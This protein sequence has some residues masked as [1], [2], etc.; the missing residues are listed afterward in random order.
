MKKPLME[1]RTWALVASAV[2]GGLVSSVVTTTWIANAQGTKPTTVMVK[3]TPKPV[4]QEAPAPPVVEVVRL[5]DNAFVVIKD[6]GDAAT[7][8]Y[9][10]TEAGF[11]VLKGGA[12]KYFY[13]K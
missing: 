11:P 2:V 10:D 8:L 12:K 13:E 4:V 9:F 1:N 3:A 6:H 7:T 5:N